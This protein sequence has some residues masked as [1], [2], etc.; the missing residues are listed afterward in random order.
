MITSEEQQEFYDGRSDD[1][2]LK[3]L[4]YCKV[5]AHEVS[6]EIYSRCQV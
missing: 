3:E 2:D 6:H 4:F 5:S 1:K